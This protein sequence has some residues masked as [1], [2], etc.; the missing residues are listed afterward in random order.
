M[1]NDVQMIEV[2]VFQKLTSHILLLKRVN[3]PC[4]W[5]TVTGGVENQETTI[6]TAKREIMEETGVNCSDI[7]DLKHSY[8][9]S[10]Q[11]DPRHFTCH[12][13]FAEFENNKIELNNEHDAYQWLD[14]QRAI[15]LI[16]FEDQKENLR[17]TQD[18]YHLLTR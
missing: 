7:Y 12:C 4:V 6:E 17:K 18:L 11:H 3:P 5:S 15:E 16:P 2:V 10:P 13:Y 9:F 1:S 8:R 14:F